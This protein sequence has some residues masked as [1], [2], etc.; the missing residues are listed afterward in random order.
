MA[1]SFTVMGDNLTLDLVLCRVYSVSAQSLVEDTLALNPGLAALGLV[2]PFGTEIILPDR[3][4][5]TATETV[6]VVSLFGDT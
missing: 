2:L 5:A 4:S 6:S 1:N 3:P